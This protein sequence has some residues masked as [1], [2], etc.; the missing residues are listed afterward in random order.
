MTSL[1]PLRLLPLTAFAAA[2]FALDP[3]ASADRL[4]THDGRMMEVKKARQLE[5]GSYRLTFE[6]GEVIC[7]AELIASVEIEGDMSDYVPKDD[8]ER[9]KLEKGFVRYK[10]R[11]WTQVAYENE[12]RKEAEKT[13]ERTEELAAHSDWYN[14]LEKETKHFIVR[15]NAGPEILDFY[16]DLMETWYKEFD[17]WIGIDPPPRLRRTKMRVNVFKSMEDFHDNNAAGLGG[18]VLGY[19]SWNDESLNFYHDFEDPAFSYHV[20]LHEGTHLLTYLIDPQVEPPTWVNEGIAELLGAAKVT[21]NKRGKIELEHGQI[22]LFRI[23]TVQEAI[24]DGSFIGLEKL[25]EFVG[26]PIPSDVYAHAWSLLYF[27]NNS[28]KQYKKGFD[29]FFEDMYAP[30][31]DMEVEWVPFP[32][33]QGTAKAPKKGE[34]RRFLLKHLREDDVEKLEEEWK[35]FIAGI[36]L[37]TPKALFER[38]YRSVRFWDDDTAQAMR[39]LN[40]AIS[41][42]YEDPRAYWARGQLHMRKGGRRA[43]IEDYEKAVELA[44]LDPRYR[45]GLAGALSDFGAWFVPEGV[46]VT[47]RGGDPRSRDRLDGTDEELER[48]RIQFALA[49]EMD[50]DNGGRA[51][52]YQRY[53]QALEK[54]KQNGG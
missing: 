44:P 31:K 5:D 3:P 51:A 18:G 34:T 12:L 41:G 28:S 52:H 25:F 11:W 1:F 29:K 26:N 17:R 36:E 16:A 45:S 33:I 15:S 21:V 27:L 42:G 46:K 4:L 39:D 53:L 6:H 40:E 38:G 19:F 48:A 14:A 32:N 24:K 35:E 2:L 43:A 49:M 50:P 7:P 47:I 37:D 8:N 30:P 20:A 9:E 54:H 23:L 13:R 22:A 10:G